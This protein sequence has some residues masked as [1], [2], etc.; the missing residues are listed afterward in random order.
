MIAQE[1][2]REQ[3]KTACD[4]AAELLSVRARLFDLDRAEEE[5][6]AGHLPRQP[7]GVVGVV[8]GAVTGQRGRGQEEEVFTTLATQDPGSSL[9][10]DPERGLGA[11][12]SGRGGRLAGVVTTT[13]PPQTTQSARDTAGREP[14]AIPA[15]SSSA[16]VPTPLAGLG[17]AGSTVGREWYGMDLDGVDPLAL[18]KNRAELWNKEEEL[19]EMFARV[20]AGLPTA[21]GGVDVLTVEELLERIPDELLNKSAEHLG[22]DEKIQNMDPGEK[23]KHLRVVLERLREVLFNATRGKLV[24]GFGSGDPMARTSHESLR[25]LFQALKPSLRGSARYAR[26][27]IGVRDSAAVSWDE[28][29]RAL[30]DEDEMNLLDRFGQ[31]YEGEPL[32]KSE[33][34]APTSSG[35]GEESAP[36]DLL[37]LSGQ[38]LEAGGEPPELLTGSSGSRIVSGRLVEAEV[39]KSPKDGVAKTRSPTTPPGKTLC[40]NKVKLF[41]CERCMI[42]AKFIRIRLPPISPPPIPPPLLPPSSSSSSHLP[43]SHLSLPP[44]FRHDSWDRSLGNVFTL[45]QRSR[46][47]QRKTFSDRSGAEIVPRR[48]TILLL[49]KLQST[50]SSNRGSIPDL[51]PPEKA[52]RRVAGCAAAERPQEE[53]E[54][55]RARCDRGQKAVQ[56]GPKT[57]ESRGSGSR[58]RGS[59]E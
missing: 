36:A 5:W 58:P 27:L 21:V 22:L 8:P 49:V 15:G 42:H 7:V 29:M 38:L 46:V 6:A 17:P 52:P 59:V 45:V 4:L 35:D 56:K 26:E 40:C 51:P 57:D 20:R 33:L 48:S 1:I 14:T 9:R 47:V 41:S 18:E 28:H 55:P 54:C 37:T 24:G 19:L 25:G 39:P 11:A 30:F 50:Q 10:K 34:G 53:Q 44:H 13:T 3:Y 23:K 32:T 2:L 43:S 16:R 31:P 12:I